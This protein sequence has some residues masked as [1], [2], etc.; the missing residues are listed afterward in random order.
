MT[1]TPGPGPGGSEH[2]WSRSRCRWGGRLLS[3]LLHQSRAVSLQSQRPRL[4]KRETLSRCLVHG[5]R[6]HVV[7]PSPPQCLEGPCALFNGLSTS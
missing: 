1:G 3:S 4:E 7:E 6:S 5:G 2:R